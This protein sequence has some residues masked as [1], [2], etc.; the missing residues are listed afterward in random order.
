MKI[1]FP[2]FNEPPTIATSLV[3]VAICIV[4]AWIL[5]EILLFM[6]KYVSGDVAYWII[7]WGSLGGVIYGLVRGHIT[8]SKE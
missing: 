8:I 5:F 7:L 2:M 6:A 3:A 4:A 1:R